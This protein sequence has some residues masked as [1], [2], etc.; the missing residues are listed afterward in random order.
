MLSRLLKILRVNVLVAINKTNTNR[1]KTVV[2]SVKIDN[3]TV[4]E[5]TSVLN[6]TKTLNRRI[7][8]L[9]SKFLLWIYLNIWVI[10]KNFFGMFKGIFWSGKNICRYLYWDP[11]Q[12]KF[13][14][15]CVY[16]W[17]GKRV[18]NYPNTQDGRGKMIFK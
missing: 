3:E 8:F 5:K 12:N 6:F 15:R 4:N 18:Y 7:F 17:S 13:R 1:V 11:V 2:D 14:T 16:A 10:G 9:L